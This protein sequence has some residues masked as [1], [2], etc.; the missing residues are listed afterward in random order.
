MMSLKSGLVAESTWALDTLNILLHDDRTVGFFYLKHHHSLLQTLID[1]FKK[2]L[3]A[4]FEENFEILPKYLPG[5]EGAEP[6]PCTTEGQVKVEEARVAECLFRA[7]EMDYDVLSD[8]KSAAATVGSDRGEKAEIEELANGSTVPVASVFSFGRMKLGKSDDLSH[9]RNPSIHDDLFHPSEDGG[10]EIMPENERRALERKS[11]LQR[12]DQTPVAELL[13]REALLSQVPLHRF[14]RLGRSPRRREKSFLEDIQIREEILKEL[15]GDRRT[16]SDSKTAE[17]ESKKRDLTSSQSNGNGSSKTTGPNSKATKDSPKSPAL[18]TEESEVYK[19]EPLPLW[20]VSPVRELL[21]GRC[22]C[23]SNILRSLSFIP[24]NDLEFSQNPG[25]LILLGRLLTLHHCH[26]LRSKERHIHTVVD[27]KHKED[28]IVS[29]TRGVRVASNREENKKLCAVNGETT[30]PHKEEEKMECVADEEENIAAPC[31]ENE[32]VADLGRQEEPTHLA[33][34]DYWWWECLEVLRENTLV[35]LSNISGQ[36]DLSLFPESISYPIVDGLLHWAV[37]PCAHA[38]DPLPETA[39]VSS[40]S[41]QRL[42]LETLAKMSISEVN[43]DFILATPPLMRLDLLFSHL[44]QFIG[45][46]KHP[47]MRQFALVLLSNMAQGN[48]SASRLVGQQKMVVFLL[49]E[50]IEIAEHASCMS[51]GQLVG[52]HNPDDPN[53]LSVAMLR[54]AATTLHCLS[55]VPTNRTAFLP[56]R[57]RMLYLATSQYVEPSVSSILMDMLF[58]LGKL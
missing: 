32:H 39:M 27:V 17:C 16:E 26:L 20:S 50:C 56:Y 2:A 35:I 43:V 53:S 48:E 54:R 38:V 55:K 21:Q 45:Q 46:K 8:T 13:H 3:L 57:D 19:K 51:G 58:E 11:K 31:K 29:D 18:L 25:I 36:L 47:V 5:R 24:G 1:H 23:I 41:P 52:G 34:K 37:C 44:V 6:V 14:G 4:I 28:A 30:P 49:L 7:N 40:L 22:L 42:V 15:E 9:I 10:P 33:Y 12:I